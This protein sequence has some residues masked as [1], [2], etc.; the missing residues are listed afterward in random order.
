MQDPYE[1]EI[2]KVA[3]HMNL[4][5]MQVDKLRRWFNSVDEDGSNN[6]DYTEFRTMIFNAHRSKGI[7]PEK[8]FGEKRVHISFI[9][10]QC[11]SS[12]T[13]NDYQFRMFWKHLHFG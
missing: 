5:S 13:R 12:F 6:I 9:L 4:D 8:D 10:H 7:D 1:I 2:R 3:K 11:Y